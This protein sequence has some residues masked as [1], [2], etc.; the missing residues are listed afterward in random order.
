MFCTVEHRPYIVRRRLRVAKTR[1]AR[2]PLSEAANWATT[3]VVDLTTA[4]AR[5]SRPLRRCRF[6]LIKSKREE[7]PQHGDLEHLAPPRADTHSAEPS[8]PTKGTEHMSKRVEPSITETAF[9]CPHCGALASQTWF[10][11]R[12]DAVSNEAKAPHLPDPEILDRIKRNDQF[13]AP[14]K[15]R[16]TTY[17]ERILRSDVFFD[18]ADDGSYQRR[19]IANLHISQCYNCKELSIWLHDKLLYPATRAGVE[20]NTDLND[21]IKRDFEEARSILNQS[22]RG[23][24]ALLR[25]ALQKLC[26]QLGESGDNIDKDI[27]SLVS[28]GLN[29][30]IQKALDVVRVVGNEAVHPGTLDL[31]DDR[32]TALKLFG[33]I[34]AIAQQMITHPK[35]VEALYGMLPEAKRAGIDARNAKALE[36][37]K[38]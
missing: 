5:Q 12:A 27:A 32:D 3:G 15:Q 26:K 11:T 22:P 14:T 28:K 36:K 35:E 34:N 18:I 25:L 30:T 38:E 24:A 17:F 13:D 37:A 2:S 16:L 21:D 23:A 9:N 19:N 10:T 4:K 20:P 33:L 7:R 6:K 1:K 8:P 31:R 29:V